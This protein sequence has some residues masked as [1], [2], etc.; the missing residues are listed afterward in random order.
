MVGQDRNGRLFLGRNGDGPPMER[1]PKLVSKMKD[2]LFKKGVNLFDSQSNNYYAL[3]E[4]FT[5]KL[6]GSLK[7]T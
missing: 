4:S 5:N 1:S 2:L 7:I 6:L 3:I